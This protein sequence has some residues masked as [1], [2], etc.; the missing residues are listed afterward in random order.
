MKVIYIAGP[1]TATN[2]WEIEKNIR[3]AED[4]LFEVWKLDA[5]GVCPHSNTRY[6]HGAFTQD[7]MIDGTLEIMKRCD[8]VLVVPD[9]NYMDSVGTMGEIAVAERFEMPVFYT[10]QQLRLWL[11]NEKRK[12]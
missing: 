10:I 2:A 8:A 12:R 7:Q 4:A 6:F 3:K 11:N 9:S 1:F 5:A